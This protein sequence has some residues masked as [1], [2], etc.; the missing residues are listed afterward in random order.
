MYRYVYAYLKDTK[1]EVTKC[2]CTAPVFKTRCTFLICNSFIPHPQS[3]APDA[4]NSTRTWR[5]QF[6]T[7]SPNLKLWFGVQLWMVQ[8]PASPTSHSLPPSIHPLPKKP[9][10]THPQ[11]SERQPLLS[12]SKQSRWVSHASWSSH[13][14]LSIT[15]KW[16][17]GFAHKFHIHKLEYIL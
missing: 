14:V 12:K 7:F 1:Q 3:S 13:P 6:C 2:K 16:K 10:Y 17:T 11:A 15:L 5:S 4:L 8:M 9:K